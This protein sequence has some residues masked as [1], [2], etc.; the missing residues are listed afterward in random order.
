MKQSKLTFVSF[1]VICNHASQP[2]AVTP[3]LKSKPTTKR[4]ASYYWYDP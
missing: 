4:S 3:D 1:G 2:A